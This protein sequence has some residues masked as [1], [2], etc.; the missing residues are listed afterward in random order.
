MTHRLMSPIVEIREINGKN[1]EEVIDWCGGMI[2]DN[3]DNSV[4]VYFYTYDPEYRVNNRMDFVKGQTVFVFPP[5]IAKL[6]NGSFISFE[7]QHIHS[8]LEPI[9]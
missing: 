6:E 1:Y 9:A 4:T 8:A 3:Q 2:I 5:Y 7:S